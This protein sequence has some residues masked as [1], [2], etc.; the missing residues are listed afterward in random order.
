MCGAAARDRT[1]DIL[2]TNQV[3]YQ[4]S[5]EGR[6]L[7]LLASC[8]SAVRAG[9]VLRVPPRYPETRTVLARVCAGAGKGASSSAKPS[10]GQGLEAPILKLMALSQGAGSVGHAG[11]ADSIL[12]LSLRPR[13]SPDL[14]PS[15]K[16]GQ[17]SAYRQ[18][19]FGFKITHQ[20]L[21][22][23]SISA[24]RYRS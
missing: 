24:F 21:V 14:L 20:V 7:A 23:I 2:I 15:V 22:L 16:T 10:I 3:L 18:T 11:H 9:F 5:Y 6:I 19:I 1:P 8:W 17:E 4:L 12:R 13:L